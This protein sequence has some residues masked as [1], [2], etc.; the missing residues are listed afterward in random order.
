MRM[1]LSLRASSRGLM[2]SLVLPIVLVPSARATD[3]GAWSALEVGG[4]RVPLVVRDAARDRIIV[5]GGWDGAQVRTDVWT[6]S[7][8]GT[9]AWG[10]L[11][12]VGP[13][14]PAL[15]DGTAV[16]DPVGDR[17]LLFGGRT[18]STTTTPVTY[19][20]ELWELSLRDHPEWTRL[21]P[22]GTPPAPRSEHSAIYDP[23]RRC[24]VVY[25]GLDAVEVFTE[26][27]TLSLEGPPVWR[28]LF[29]AWP[30]PARHGH[31]AIFDPARDCM[32]VIGGSSADEVLAFA[33]G[34]TV[35]WSSLSP[36]GASP[37]GGYGFLAVGDTPRD[38]IVVWDPAAGTLRGIS[39][40]EAP[41]WTMLEPD[42]DTPWEWGTS[43]SGPALVHDPV[44]DRMVV[45]GGKLAC[46]S[47]GSLYLDVLCA[48]SLGDPP[49]W[50][51]LAPVSPAAPSRWGASVI[52]DPRRNRA[53]VHGGFRLGSCPQGDEPQT[54]ALDDACDWTPMA[55]GGWS[56]CQRT[57]HC[58]V[59]DSSRDRMIIF[60]GAA[61][62]EFPLDDVWAMSLRDDAAWTM[63]TPAGVSPAPRSRHGAI[64]DPIRDRMIVFG[65]RDGGWLTDV[66]ELSLGDSMAWTEVV[67]SGV[68]PDAG[69]YLAVLDP[70]RDR[71]IVIGGPSSGVWA[72][73]L[74]GSAG[75]IRL[76]P[77]GT[78]P[79]LLYECTAF[80]D[81]V[82]DRMVIFG[83]HGSE[84]S[85][86][87]R[88]N[89][90]TLSLDGPLSWRWL[91]PA[92][93][94]PGRRGWPV[95][96]HDPVRDRVLMSGGSGDTGRMDGAWA[97]TWSAPI[98]PTQPALLSAEAEPGL[99]RLTWYAVTG[100]GLSATVHRCV[101]DGAWSAMGRITAD[102]AGQL[103]YEDRTVTPGTRYGYRLGVLE[104]GVETFLGEAWVDVPKA[105]ALA[106]AGARPNPATSELSVA[107]T[108][109]DPGPASGGCPPGAHAPAR[110][111]AFDLAGRRVA[112]RDV[113]ALGAGSHVVKL[114]EGVRL[115]CGVYVV[116]LT[117]DEHTLTTR[118]VVVR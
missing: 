106:L 110:L 83:G 81:A 26:V 62:N 79:P 57:F 48:L 84:T 42:G 7:L 58:A 113:G 20:N 78:P 89:A 97:L 90:W 49:A 76:E 65:G 87:F 77:S 40:G 70:V 102:G 35:A 88:N 6:A 2:L 34:D 9:P 5:L 10:R 66:W 28:V 29:P 27:W 94:V 61:Y 111:E 71:M 82:R 15:L 92:G 52:R 31:A 117:W 23:V 104:N 50:T 73:S 63:L 85:P 41:V 118:A 47:G 56:P 103:V 25:G 19:S 39:L 116:R 115:A 55:P 37:G 105:S 95:V 12:P 60:G 21:Q 44:R 22:A 72:L 67:P 45:F 112:S 59:P 98:V 46:S 75:W 8:D 109:P 91:V 99:V 74:A 69:Y 3:D 54:L 96:V 32:V 11:D 16:Y 24:M 53:I 100:N 33:L 17:V 4:R 43:V 38:R 101:G 107:F 64:H 93:A 80:Y 114:G 30:W 86:V 68:P 13:A 51:R 36:S 1:P 14:P 108:L 18:V